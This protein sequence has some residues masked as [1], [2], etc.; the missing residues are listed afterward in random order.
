LGSSS[1]AV[2]AKREG[3]KGEAAGFREERGTGAS[4]ERRWLP[5]RVPEMGEGGGV[6]GGVVGAIPVFTDHVD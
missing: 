6:E 5:A 1:V 3:E 4:A 2:S